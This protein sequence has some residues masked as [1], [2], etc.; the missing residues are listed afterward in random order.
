MV[1]VGSSVDLVLCFV[2]FLFLG[3]YGF[4]D[5]LQQIAFCQ[6]SIGSTPR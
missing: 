1:A 4:G 2:E 6:G 3:E 5:M